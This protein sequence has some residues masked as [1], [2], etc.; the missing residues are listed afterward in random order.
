M[1]LPVAESVPGF[2]GAFFALVRIQQPPE[3]SLLHP[4]ER[5]VW[6]SLAS[7]ARRREW[8]SGRVAARSALA[9]IGGANA[10]VLSDERGVPTL[11]GP[12]ADQRLV[13]I[14]HGRRW[15]VAMAM[16]RAETVAGVGVDL[17]EPEDLVRL[18]KLRH[19]VFTEAERSHLARHDQGLA[20]AWGAKEALAKATATGMWA[21]AMG[22]V[23]LVGFEP[24]SGALLV[25]VAGAQLTERRLEDGSILVFAAASP[26]L[27]KHARS[28]ADR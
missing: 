15:S 14:S 12:G 8:W 10:W 11:H 5:R 18:D 1:Q 16:P 21:F 9:A 25:D 13:S 6:A 23:S 26:E 20:A 4:E 19:R 24:E 3:L 2:A 7:E 17:V 22:G 27:L 28:I